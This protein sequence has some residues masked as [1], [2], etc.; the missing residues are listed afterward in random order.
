MQAIGLLA[1]GVAHDFNNLLT[2]INSSVTML[3]DDIGADQRGQVDLIAI[4]DAGDRAAQLTRQLLL[5]SRKAVFESRLLDLNQVV[6]RASQLLL[7]L[8]GEN[9][10]VEMTLAPGLPAVRG[11]QAQLEQVLLNLALNGR[12]AMA[13]GARC[14]SPPAGRHLA[15]GPAADPGHSGRALR[16]PAGGG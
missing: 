8:I 9:I 13:G 11:D 2:I 14:R 5:F 12:D 7:R 16:A 6:Q 10:R 3:L 1:G 15:R 4:R